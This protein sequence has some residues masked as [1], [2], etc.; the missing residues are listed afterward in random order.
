MRNCTDPIAKTFSALLGQVQNADV[1]LE[2]AVPHDGKAS[3]SG[4]RWGWRRKYQD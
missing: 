1:W 4:T 2:Q 3:K